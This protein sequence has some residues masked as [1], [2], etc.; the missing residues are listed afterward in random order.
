MIQGEEFE[1]DDNKFK[2]TVCG[3]TIEFE[4]GEMEGEVPD[5]EEIEEMS[6]MDSSLEM[7]DKVEPEFE[8]EITCECGARYTVRKSPGISGFV[9]IQH[10]GSESELAENIQNDFET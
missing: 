5:L 9:V 6:D 10:T 2:C 4:A 8:R 7:G 3:E 1:I